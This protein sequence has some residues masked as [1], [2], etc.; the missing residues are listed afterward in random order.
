MPTSSDPFIAIG[1]K[2]TSLALELTNLDSPLQIGPN[3]IGIN[4]VNWSQGKFKD[5]G[6]RAHGWVSEAKSNDPFELYPLSRAI[7]EARVVHVSSISWESNGRRFS[8][9]AFFP[10]GWTNGDPQPT[11]VAV[12]AIGWLHGCLERESNANNL[13]DTVGRFEFGRGVPQ[14]S[15]ASDL[16][17]RPTPRAWTREELEVAMG[18]YCTVPFGLFH[19]KN[20]LII[21]VSER[22]GRSPASL[23]MKLCNFAS[24]DPVHQARGVK[25]LS[26]ASRADREIW[27]EFHED[28]ENEAFESQQQ[29]A[30]LFDRPIE[31]QAGISLNELPTEG[32]ER[33]RVVRQRVNQ[34]FFRSAVL[35]AYDGRCCITDLSLPEL[36]ISSHIIPW[37]ENTKT[38]MNPANGL[39]LNA[40]HDKAFDRGLISI[41]DDL[42][43]MVS[44]AVHRYARSAEVRSRLL[45]FEGAQLRRPDRFAPD[46]E[47]LAWHRKHRFQCAA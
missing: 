42:R 40:L 45:D 16:T 18:I 11:Y 21:E 10:A 15:S 14:L 46:A 19:A 31:Q 26:G 20:P 37:A 28:W 3:G 36:L 9:E 34:Q 8:G 41:S 4:G 13:R 32:L 23:A 12:R 39:C 29:L 6:K 2:G 22:M 33:E 5:L 44:P 17:G 24:L 27:T 47:F 35:S 7:A 38:R 30:T 1:S 25:G 43:V